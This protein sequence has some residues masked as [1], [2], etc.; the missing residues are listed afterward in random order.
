MVTKNAANG[1]RIPRSAPDA[2][3]RPNLNAHWTRKTFR[4]LPC[5]PCAIWAF[6]NAWDELDIR[7]GKLA[8]PFPVEPEF[9][10][11]FAEGCT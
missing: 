4:P 9:V 7:V 3:V 11:D 8:T 10:R 6:A 1:G 5:R 2:F